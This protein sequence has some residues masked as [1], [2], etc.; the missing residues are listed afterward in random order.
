MASSR[1][2]H[3]RSAA[4]D[5]RR[6]RRRGRR[7]LRCH[8]APA[9]TGAVTWQAADRA[10]SRLG[11]PDLN[12]RTGAMAR[13]SFGRAAKE[14]SSRSRVVDPRVRAPHA[15]RHGFGHVSIGLT[16]S[17]DRTEEPFTIE[18][19]GTGSQEVLDAL[20]PLLIDRPVP[21]ARHP[22]L[23]RWVRAARILRSGRRSMDWR[24]KAI[25]HWVIS[26]SPRSG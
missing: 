7:V 3:H 23:A 17:N 2:R 20:E 4:G 25:G 13:R 22:R 26:L 8:R 10:R 16:R 21:A 11:R 1:S 19:L 5:R 14:P 9:D 15:R 24:V 6:T 12:P 18:A